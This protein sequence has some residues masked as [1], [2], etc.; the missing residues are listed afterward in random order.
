MH[1]IDIYDN[2]LA[3]LKK[4]E[5]KI[6]IKFIVSF[7]I[8]LIVISILICIKYPLIYNFEGIASNDDIVLYLSK[9]DLKKLKGDTIIKNDESIKYNIRSIVRLENVD[10]E[11]YAVRIYTNEE[12]IDNDIIDFKIN[13]GS[14]TL[15]KSF[16]K[17][18]WKGFNTW[19]I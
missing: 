3:V 13:D 9:Q 10:L 8:G 7:I 19:R 1:D 12:Y 2:S 18:I 11:Y 14:T 16:V 15:L 5:E 17:K 4:K 6:Y